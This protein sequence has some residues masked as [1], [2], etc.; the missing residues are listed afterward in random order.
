[1]GRRWWWKVLQ[2]VGA[3]TETN[4]NTSSTSFVNTGGLPS[5]SFTPS[6][7]SSK[8]L[9]IANFGASEGTGSNS[10]WNIYRDSSSL[11]NSTAG[12]SQLQ[13]SST[14]RFP[15]GGAVYLDSPNTTSAVTYQIRIRVSGSSF[16]FGEGCS[17]NLVA[18]EIGA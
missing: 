7:T 14:H 2:V 4:V 5:F 17:V 9:L 3:S 15:M 6:A 13:F 12:F 16:N 11:G 18:M 1:M 8:V 10:Y